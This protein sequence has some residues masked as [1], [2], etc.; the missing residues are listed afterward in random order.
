[1]EVGPMSSPS[2]STLESYHQV[3]RI[4]TGGYRHTASPLSSSGD[5]SKWRTTHTDKDDFARHTSLILFARYFLAW[6]PSCCTSNWIAALFLWLLLISHNYRHQTAHT[7]STLEPTSKLPKE[8]RNW[9]YS[10][11]S[12][13]GLKNTNE[14]SLGSTSHRTSA[15]DWH[16]G[17]IRKK[18]ILTT[19]GSTQ[20]QPPGHL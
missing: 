8:M 5:T 3:K 7:G 12:D 2:T 10:G 17:D 15:E 4:V 9:R 16:C 6:G 19:F 20:F 14:N 11:S 18:E 13:Q 1:M